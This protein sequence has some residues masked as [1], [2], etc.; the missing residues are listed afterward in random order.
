MGEFGLEIG[1][2]RFVHA[3]ML[4]GKPETWQHKLSLDSIVY[5]ER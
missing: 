2:T 5:S 1:L 4:V 3:A